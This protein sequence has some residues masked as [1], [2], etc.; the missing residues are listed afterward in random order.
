MIT[1]TRLRPLHEAPEPLHLFSFILK[2][3]GLFYVVAVVAWQFLH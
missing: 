2:G 1:D 3:V